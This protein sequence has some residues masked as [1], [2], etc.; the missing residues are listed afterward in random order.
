MCHFQ[1]QPLP[2]DRHGVCFF[3]VVQELLFC[4]SRSSHETTGRILFLEQNH[5]CGGAVSFGN[6][7]RGNCLKFKMLNVKKNVMSSVGAVKCRVL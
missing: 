3:V 5:Y 2:V 1:R 6:S 7:K 4:V